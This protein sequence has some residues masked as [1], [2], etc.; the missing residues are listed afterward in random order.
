MVMLY[1]P[2]KM[3]TVVFNLCLIGLAVTIM[4]VKEGF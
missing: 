4:N 2:I 3:R 1:V